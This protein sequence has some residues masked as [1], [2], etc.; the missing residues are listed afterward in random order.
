MIAE[1]KNFLLNSLLPVDWDLIRQHLSI[2]EL[3]HYQKLVRLNRYPDYVYFPED[4]LITVLALSGY[5]EQADV[6]TIGV[7]GCTAIEVI[8]GC[9]RADHDAVVQIGGRAL[10]LETRRLIEASHSSPS[11]RGAL[12]KYAYMTLTQVRETALA[13]ARATIFQR[14]ARWILIACRGTGHHELSIT[15]EDLSTSLGV[16]RAGVTNALHRLVDAGAIELTRGHIFISDPE[17]L[18][19]AACGYCS[20]IGIPIADEA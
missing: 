11:L 8:L 16:R 9:E 10:R 4:S 20:A 2:V 1:T 13:N 15:H 12:L 3:A 19:R 18:R 7:E 17:R 14:A 5:R 6:G